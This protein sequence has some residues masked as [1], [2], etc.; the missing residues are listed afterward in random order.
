[1]RIGA[2]G[3]SAVGVGNKSLDQPIDI[4]KVSTSFFVFV[5]CDC[6]CVGEKLESILNGNFFYKISPI[7][8]TC[9]CLTSWPSL[10]SAAMRL[11]QRHQASVRGSTYRLCL[12]ILNEHRFKLFCFVVASV[13]CIVGCVVAGRWRHSRT[14]VHNSCP[15]PFF[16]YSVFFFNFHIMNERSARCAMRSSRRQSRTWIL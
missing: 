15:L 14:F 11:P 12:S 4:D 3:L 9:V 1:M 16:C 10:I 13:R 6:R 7:M 2:A 8:L 5:R